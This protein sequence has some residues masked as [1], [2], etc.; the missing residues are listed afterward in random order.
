MLPP[1]TFLF[2]DIVSQRPRSLP[3]CLGGPA[4]S[5]GSPVSAPHCRGY[6]TPSYAWH[7]YIGA[8]DSTQ[9]FMLAQQKYSPSSHFSSPSYG[10]TLG[11]DV[12][13]VK[14]TSR[15]SQHDWKYL[16]PLSLSWLVDFEPWDSPY[17]CKQIPQGLCPCKLGG[18]YLDLLFHWGVFSKGNAWVWFV[19]CC[20]YSGI[21]RDNELE[22]WKGSFWFLLIVRNWQVVDLN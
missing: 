16:I 3:F 13:R 21:Q 2:W 10:C 14:S 17:L 5:Q 7:F 15:H 9:V 8:N 6:S 20:P 4:I 11:R 22:L 19:E 12:Q 18:T 1:V